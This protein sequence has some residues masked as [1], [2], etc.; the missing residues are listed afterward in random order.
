MKH[1]I[2]TL[3]LRS[4]LAFRCLAIAAV[5]SIVPLSSAQPTLFGFNDN[6]SAQQRQMETQFDTLIDRAEMDRWLRDFSSEAHHVGSPKS[7]EN[8]EAIAA[9]LRSW[10]YDVEIAEYEVL[11]P[12][13][14]TRELE[15]VAPT[16][17]TA[18]LMED[19]IDGDASTSNTDNLLP[20]YNAFS[21][22]GEVE[23]ELVFVNYGT[24][25]DYELLERYGV[26]VAG[27]IAISKYG[28]SWRGI[29]PKLAGEMGAIGT[30]IYSDPAD[31]GYGPGDVYP[32]G[33][34]KN[35]SGVQRGSV[36]DMPTYPGDVLTP[37][38]GAT[39]DVNRL[40]REEAPTITQIPVLP[41]SY[42]D[43]LPLLEAMGGAVV[44]QEWRGGL[45]ITYHL[46]PGPARV[47][48]K[49]EFDWKMVT[50]YNVIARL[51]GTSMP[52]QWIIRGNHH[53][54]WNHGAA[55]PLSGIVAMLAEAK[56]VSRLAKSGYPP[57]RTIIYAAWD[58]EEPG[59]I[60]STEWA[61][62]HA[63]ELQE[64]AVVYLNTDG[65]GRGFV[66][67][68]GS[69]VLER[70][71][72]EIMSDVED[73]QTG[74]SVQQR[75]RANLR[76]NSGSEKIRNEAK[77]RS[78]LRISPLGSGSDYTPFLQHL[79]IASA[80]MGFGGH[81]G[82]GSYH[83]MYDT[84]EH[85]TKW[86]DP[87]LIYGRTLAQ[88]AGR[89][90]LRLANAPRLPFD[91]QGFTDNVAGYIE[92]IETLADDMREKTA[93][94][95]FDIDSGVYGLVL[96]PTK[97]FGPPIPKPAV[98]Y[99]NFAPLKNALARLEDSA[100]AYQN[101][102]MSGTAASANQNYL[103]YTSERELI[104]EEGLT[105]RPWYKHHIYAPG[106]YTGYGVKTIPGVREAIE[107]RQYDQVAGQIDIAA[108]VLTN[109]AVR[110]D[111][112]GER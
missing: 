32:E 76:I 24:P 14:L 71:F 42:R 53:D 4:T 94:D 8:A 6:T 18:S 29:K 70:F 69:H 21:T 26:S 99:F 102:A 97:T 1:S 19:P 81:S 93:T 101:L 38:V 55:D 51:E 30:L 57:A 3:L 82:G 40:S 15:L 36:M 27:K 50:A 46:G 72:N 98:P 65:N 39:G 13:P 10:N 49:L 28:G 95:N 41:I 83:T 105:G 37:G 75:R 34:Y 47:R 23:A 7:K 17:F 77:N 106:F 63:A 66:N 110:L 67:V 96:D 59:L 108:E 74:V 9:L 78:D 2:Q 43:A 58:A 33:P 109:L 35:D 104:R 79:G 12:E 88:F 91:F 85:Y 48:L 44:P 68:G 62:H 45:P 100:D 89:A 64:H 22:D 31:D 20:P 25:A 56:A 107:Q 112:L 103:L 86:I 16:R 92:E 61:E 54:G 60:G 11:F 111:E 90:T 80:N 5:I 73:P 87:G 84:Y 52:D